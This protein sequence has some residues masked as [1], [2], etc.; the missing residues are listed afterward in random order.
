MPIDPMKRFKVGDRVGF[1]RP[2]L[3]GVGVGSNDP[4]WHLFGTVVGF[5]QPRYVRVKFDGEDEP[6]A[7]AAV[8]LAKP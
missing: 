5:Q 7:I 2:F 8:N 4:K 3:E 6:K 1:S